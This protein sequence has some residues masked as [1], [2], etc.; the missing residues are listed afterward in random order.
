MTLLMESD[1]QGRTSVIN[2]AGSLEFEKAG[3]GFQE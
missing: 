2:L 1:D 3:K